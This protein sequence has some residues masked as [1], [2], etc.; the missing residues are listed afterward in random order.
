MQ[1]F[2]STFWCAATDTWSLCWPGAG[3]TDSIG[4]WSGSVFGPQPSSSG[5]E[6]RVGGPVGSWIT[7]GGASD[8]KDV[9]PRGAAEAGGGCE[10]DL[11]KQTIAGPRRS[12]FK[13]IDH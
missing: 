12:H 4:F 11:S 9:S 7:K 8:S 10:N 13:G 1:S 3:S 5:V 6:L 2:Q